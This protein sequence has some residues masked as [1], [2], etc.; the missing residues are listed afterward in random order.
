MTMGGWH[1]VEVAGVADN[2]LRKMLDGF[3][4]NFLNRGADAYGAGGLEL[5]ERGTHGCYS[6]CLIVQ[7]F[8]VLMLSRSGLCQL[9]QDKR[10]NLRC[11]KPSLPM[12]GMS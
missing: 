1:T 10:Q 5:V 8:G 9:K 3:V 6:E 12:R 2:D 4:G 11:L 7:L